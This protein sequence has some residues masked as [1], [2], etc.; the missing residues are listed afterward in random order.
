MDL[1]NKNE[2][3]IND[4]PLLLSIK[5]GRTEYSVKKGDYI[6]YN[7]ASYQFCSGDGR[8]LKL[9]GFNQYRNLRLSNAMVKK[10][11]FSKM[12]KQNYRLSGI[13]LVRWLF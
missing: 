4:K 1:N 11:P 6:L 8:T 9:I 7:G 10:I 13:D 5:I 12:E 3:L 2:T